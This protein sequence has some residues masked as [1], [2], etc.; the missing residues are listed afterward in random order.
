M[1]SV[2]RNTRRR[3]RRRR[4]R[5]AIAA[6]R[7]LRLRRR[8]CRCRRCRHRHPYFPAV[9]SMFRDILVMVCGLPWVNPD[10]PGVAAKVVIDRLR[11][12]QVSVLLYLLHVI[13]VGFPCCCISRVRIGVATRRRNRF[14]LRWFARTTGVCGSE[15]RR[16][17]SMPSA[18][19]GYLRSSP[20]SSPPFGRGEVVLLRPTQG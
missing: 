10:P 13:S 12:R 18:L 9:F 1:F 7:R 4:P 5:P 14:C 3:P 11:V 15:S 6:L 16:L 2:L 19:R 8:R 20:L 17:R